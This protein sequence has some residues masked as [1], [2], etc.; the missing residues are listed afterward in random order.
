MLVVVEPILPPPE[1]DSHRCCDLLSLYHH[2]HRAEQCWEAEEEEVCRKDRMVVVVDSRHPQQNEAEEDRIVLEDSRNFWFEHSVL[3]EDN[4]PHRGG[5]DEDHRCGG[6]G[7]AAGCS[8]EEDCCSTREDIPCGDGDGEDCTAAEDPTMALFF[9]LEEAEEDDATAHAVMK[10]K[11]VSD[12][13]LWFPPNR[14]GQTVVPRPNL[15]VLV[16]RL[17]DYC[18]NDEGADDDEW[19]VVLEIAS[20]VPRLR[21]LVLVALVVVVVDDENS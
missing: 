7:D 5:G 18:E 15:V 1:E 3:E 14:V 2:H 4:S 8:G 10:K 16:P 19:V 17:A 12:W 11:H 13:N 20:V 9:D 6:G 21:P